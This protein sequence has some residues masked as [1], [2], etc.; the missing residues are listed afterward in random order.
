MY[1]NS[2]ADY[3]LLHDGAAR[4]SNQHQFP[5]ILVELR[6]GF[7]KGYAVMAVREQERWR[8]GGEIERL[9]KEKE[10]PRFSGFM[11]T[12]RLTQYAVRHGY[13]GRL[14]RRG[15]FRS[16]LCMVPPPVWE[17][18]AMNRDTGPSI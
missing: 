17:L 16:P 7:K 11:P 10:L 3:R 6:E 1:E 2:G 8:E 5:E 18:I 4:D 13:H 9:A 15:I 12:A 14:D